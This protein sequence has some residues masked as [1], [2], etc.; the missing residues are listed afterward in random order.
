MPAFGL[1]PHPLFTLLSL[2]DALHPEKGPLL[3]EGGGTPRARFASPSFPPSAPFV[4]ILC[5]FLRLCG[6]RLIDSVSQVSYRVH[7]HPWSS[8]WQA[9]FPQRLGSGTPSRIFRRFMAPMSRF[10]AH[11][12]YLSRWSWLFFR[13]CLDEHRW[14]ALA[15]PLFL[16]LLALHWVQ[17]R[18]GVRVGLKFMSRSG[19]SGVRVGLASAVKV[20]VG[21]SGLPLSPPSSACLT[22]TLPEPPTKPLSPTPTSPRVDSSLAGQRTPDA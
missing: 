3:C 4:H 17:S 1:R 9:R 13:W 7:L 18:V 10:V 21:P 15:L 11:G 5:A 14:V 19:E 20:E 8:G 2:C 12:T 6:P 16:P 22:L